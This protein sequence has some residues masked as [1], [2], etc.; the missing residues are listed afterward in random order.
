MPLEQQGKILRALETKTI[1][2]LGESDPVA[3][4]FRLVAA[5]N[6][7]MQR[8]IWEGRFR[9]DLYYRLN[10]IPAVIPPLRSRKEDIRPLVEYYLSRYCEKYSINKR[11][12]ENVYRQLESYD[13]PGNVR[14]LKN[15]IERTLLMSDS[16]VTEINII[17]LPVNQED[18]MPDAG[19]GEQFSAPTRP[20]PVSMAVAPQPPVSEP[21][22]MSTQLED[23]MKDYERTVLRDALSRCGSYNEAAS[24]LGISI[25]TMYRKVT[26]YNLEKDFNFDK[27]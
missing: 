18:Q 9:E 13:W 10:V 17:N 8:M 22:I 6:K 15:L 14:E 16:G 21:V 11:F 2:R 20:V 23:R 3:V 12:S 25:S 4:D 27:E 19:I 1:Y 24:Y 7:N 26:K 5:T